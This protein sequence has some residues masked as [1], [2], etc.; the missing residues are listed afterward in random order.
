MTAVTTRPYLVNCQNVMGLPAR[1]AM[2]ST[3]TFADAPTAVFDVFTSQYSAATAA[4]GMA[5][6]AKGELLAKVKTTLNTAIVLRNRLVKIVAAAEPPAPAEDAS[7][8]HPG[9]TAAQEVGFTLA[10]AYF[11]RDSASFTCL[12]L[13]SSAAAI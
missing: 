2:P 9:A 7:A 12:S 5:P 10:N 6:D 13:G 8:S 1:S 11:T 4:V 3:T